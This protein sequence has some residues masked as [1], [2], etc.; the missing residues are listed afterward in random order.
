MNF[1]D[2]IPS[3]MR[4]F[5]TNCIMQKEYDVK[6][7]KGATAGI[8]T[9]FEGKNYLNINSQV[10]SSYVGLG[11]YISGNTKL[12]KAKIGRFCSIGQNVVNHFGRHPAS[13]F[14]STHPCFFST[15]KQAGFT[16]TEKDLFE[17]HLYVDMAKKY[18]VCIG[19]DVWI[20]NNVLIMDGVTIGDGA[21]IGAG[22]IVT[23]NI[24]PYSIVGGVPAKLIKRRFSNEE[25]KLLLRFRWWDKDLE[26]IK[27]NQKMFISISSFI[28][29]V[30]N[31]EKLS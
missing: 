14:V 4:I 9:I 5:Y 24:E 23:R 7:A 20:G 22:A 10:Y 11:T 13:H 18:V 25:I 16:F 12:N 3:R 2:F 19:N 26:W 29:L 28:S 1:K 31:N 17:E 30:I 21:I 27:E 6:F 15:K 8:N